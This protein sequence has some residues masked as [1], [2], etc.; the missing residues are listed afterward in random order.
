IVED[1]H[2]TP[3]VE[4]LRSGVSS[5]IGGDIDYTLR[6]I[7]NHPRA[8]MAMVRLGQRDKTSRPKGAHFTVECY[9]DRAIRYQPDD[10]NVREIRGIY[11]SMVGDHAAA[12]TDFEAVVQQ[13]PANGNAHYN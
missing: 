10:M 12:V 3:E 1:H 4:L 9:I 5:A 11:R 13:Q 7:P 2:F 8:L 6:A